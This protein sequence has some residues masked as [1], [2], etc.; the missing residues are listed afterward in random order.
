MTQ[1]LK[2]QFISARMPPEITSRF[3]GEKS[4][5]GI[6]QVYFEN[7]WTSL[8]DDGFDRAAATVFCRSLGFL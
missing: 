8:C 3:Y 2:F 5:V 7:K 1:L 6:V 4:Q